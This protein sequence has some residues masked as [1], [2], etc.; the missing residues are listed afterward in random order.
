MIG[1]YTGF[2]RMAMERQKAEIYLSPNGDDGNPGSGRKPVKTIARARELV[3]KMKVAGNLPEG[4]LKIWLHGGAYPA[5]DAVAFGPEDTGVP[6]KPASWLAFPG[7]KPVFSN[8]VPT[9]DSFLEKR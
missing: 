2:Q 1:L 9:T 8:S 3:G 7:E 6:G 4:G 5:E